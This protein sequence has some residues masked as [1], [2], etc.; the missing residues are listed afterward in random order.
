ME[1]TRFVVSSWVQEGLSP[2]RFLTRDWLGIFLLCIIVYTENLMF[3]RGA[4]AASEIRPAYSHLRVKDLLY[5]AV[6][7]TTAEML[8][9]EVFVNFLFAPTVGLCR[10][11]TTDKKYQGATNMVV[12]RDKILGVSSPVGRV[13]VCEPVLWCNS[14]HHFRRL[15]S[16]PASSLATPHVSCRTH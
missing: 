11:K 8:F 14:L 2:S 3:R 13:C 5:V 10:H 16:T 1:T 15:R 9:I 6:V 7:G 4:R 12:Q